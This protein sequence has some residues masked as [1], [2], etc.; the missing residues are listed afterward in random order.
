[1]NSRLSTVADVMT[2]AVVAVGR[3]ATFPEVLETLQQ[4]KV[5]AVPVLAGDGRVVGVV[6]ET[7]LRVAREHDPDL[8]DAYTAGRLMSEPA[9]T[10]HPDSPLAEA[11]RAMA[12]GRVKRLPVVDDEG[13]LIGVVSRGDLLKIHLRTDAE[14]V[15]QVGSELR[16]VL[17]A[18]QAASVGVS[19]ED[20]RV[21]LTCGPQDAGTLTRMAAGVRAVPGVVDVRVATA[22]AV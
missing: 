12:R 14:L 13:F 21:T 19:V 15:E 7:D 20:G 17:T 4:W 22:A 16:G 8:V 2:R 6:S 5:R 3:S 11:G 1:M 10:V 18:D 9:I